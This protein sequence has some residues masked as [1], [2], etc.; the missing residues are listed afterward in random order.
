MTPNDLLCTNLA[1]TTAIRSPKTILAHP[2]QALV[3]SRLKNENTS[4][5]RNVNPKDA[6]TLRIT[7]MKSDFFLSGI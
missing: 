3:L 5:V 2:N 7:R 6:H 1:K 4:A